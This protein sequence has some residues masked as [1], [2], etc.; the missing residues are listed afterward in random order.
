MSRRCIAEFPQFMVW[1]VAEKEA[2][3]CAR[4]WKPLLRQ[5][6]TQRTEIAIYQYFP[7]YAA[8]HNL[9][10]RTGLNDGLGQFLHTQGI[11]VTLNGSPDRLI[12]LT[13]QAEEKYIDF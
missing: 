10:E 5:H 6:H 8:Q 3:K 11:D 1:Y 12:F 9:A 4:P 2:G 7:E 13:A